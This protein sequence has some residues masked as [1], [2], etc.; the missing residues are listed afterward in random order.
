MLSVQGN[1]LILIYVSIYRLLHVKR[2]SPNPT[3]LERGLV[4]TN[5]ASNYQTNSNDNLQSW[6][7]I[8]VYLYLPTDMVDAVAL[9]HRAT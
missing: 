2:I 9:F 3:Q 5:N 1:G 8:H 4:S 7:T 6:D